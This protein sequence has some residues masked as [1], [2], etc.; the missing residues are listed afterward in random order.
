M[1]LESSNFKLVLMLMTGLMRDLAAYH[2]VSTVHSKVY[3]VT[4]VS[5]LNSPREV[6][7]L[8]SYKTESWEV[9]FPGSHS[10]VPWLPNS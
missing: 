1:G 7:S 9:S 10:M 3:L 5:S 8:I 2:M 6:P 4:E